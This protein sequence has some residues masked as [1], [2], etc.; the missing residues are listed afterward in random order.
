MCIWLFIY[1]GSI[2]GNTLFSAVR[3]RLF[4]RSSLVGAL[5]SFNMPISIMG[6]TVRQLS[7]TWPPVTGIACPVSYRCSTQYIT[8]LA[9]SEGR[10]PL[11]MGTFAS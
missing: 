4:S 11:F 3:R 5:S 9:T 1:R 6:A 2:G 10:Q 7:M 8:A